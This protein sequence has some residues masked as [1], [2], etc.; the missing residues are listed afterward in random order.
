MLLGSQPLVGDAEAMPNLPE[1]SP[2]LEAQIDTQVAPTHC[3]GGG[4]DVL[5]SEGHEVGGLG[6]AGP[7]RAPVQHEAGLGITGQQQDKVPKPIEGVS[8]SIQGGDVGVP[9]GASWGPNETEPFWGEEE[10]QMLVSLHRGEQPPVLR[11]P[12]QSPPGCC[13]VWLMHGV[14]VWPCHPLTALAQR[15]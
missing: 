1:E 14:H 9:E 13:K 12:Q 6:R 8:D 10:K 2:P 7:G 11:W 4:R 5:G 15:R 3:C